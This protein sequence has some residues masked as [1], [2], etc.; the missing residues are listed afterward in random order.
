[1]SRHCVCGVVR[2]KSRRS[3]KLQFADK[4]SRFTTEKIMSAQSFN[5]AFEFPPNRGL[6][7][8]FYIF[9]EQLS[10]KTISRQFSD[11]PKFRGIVIFFFLPL[12][13]TPLTSD[14]YY[15]HHSSL[16][17]FSVS[18]WALN[19]SFLWNFL[20]FRHLAFT[21]LTSQI[22]LMDFLLVL[23]S[24]SSQFSLTLVISVACSL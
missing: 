15:F 12:A 4:Y 5:F 23:F 19:V 6:S 24:F 18:V 2:L 17:Y 8:K 16:L 1:M 13:M 14:H 10:N 21:R 7:S 11:C 20:L 9:K 3:R 22:L